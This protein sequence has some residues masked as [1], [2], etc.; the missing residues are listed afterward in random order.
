[1]NNLL[2]N[3]VKYSDQPVQVRVEVSRSAPTTLQIDVSDNGIGIPKTSQKRVFDRF[4]R[5]PGEEVNKRRGTGLGLFVVASLVKSLDGQVKATDGVNG[6]G[7][8]M[9]VALPTDKQVVEA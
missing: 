4:Y 2:D 9:S 7:T 8:M 1:L 3:A 6:K 5:V